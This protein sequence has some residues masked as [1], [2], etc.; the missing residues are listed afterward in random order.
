V[1]L[2][3]RAVFVLLLL[4]SMASATRAAPRAPNA[5]PTGLA[6]RHR[7]GQTFLTWQEQPGA[8]LRYRVYRHTTAIDAGNLAQATL[9]YDG[10]PQDSGRFYAN[11][12]NVD[13]GGVW[14]ERYV[15][16]FVVEDGGAEL[17]A[18][19][20]LLVWTLAPTD[21]G[22][23][24]S[25][26]GYYA[27]TTVDAG[28][29]NRTDFGAGNTVGPVAESVADPLPVEIAA[30]GIDPGG[31]I[32]VQYMPLRDWNVTFH[33][34]NPGNIFY[35]LDETSPAVANAIQY[36]YD[37][38]VY[39]PRAADCGGAL[40]A[41][42]PVVVSLHGWG[43]NSYGP[44][45]EDPDPYGWCVYRIYPI[46][47]SET[48]WFGFARNHDYRGDWTPGAGD[49]IAN[50]T[51]RRV[52][53]MV[54]DLLRDPPGPPADANRVFIFGSSM[55]GSGTLAFALRYPNV[56]AA[57]YA[58]QPMTNYATSGDGGGIDWRSD[59]TPKWGEV[60]DDLPV[61]ITG[62]GN[63]ADG[64]QAENGTGVWT[65]QNHQAQAVARRASDAVPLGI[66]HGVE[67]DV[68]EW[69]TQGRPIYPALNSAQQVWGGAAVPGGHSWTGFGGSLYN[70]DQDFAASWAPFQNFAPRRGETVPG[71][72]N[73]S[74]NALLPPTGVG[75]YN[76]GVRWSAS[77]DP[78]D[79]APVDTPTRWE[80]SFCYQDVDRYEN[81]CGTGQPLTVDVTPRRV[82][83]FPLVA[84][85]GYRWENRRVSDNG[86][87]ASGNVTADADGLVTV[88]AFALNHAGGNRLILQPL[89]DLPTPTATPTPSPTPTFCPQATPEPLWVEPVVSPTD[90]LTQTIVVNIGNCE[91]VTVTT[92]SGVFT[93]TGSFGAVGNPASV[94]IDLL[95][96]VT[97]DLT[98]AARVRSS[99]SGGC[100]FGGYTL[101][102]Q[103]D[104][105]GGALRIVQQAAGVQRGFLPVIQRSAATAT[106][107]PTPTATSTSTPTSTLMPTV[108]PT[109]TPTRTP[110][111]TATTTGGAPRP[112][113]D[114]S[115]GI[116]VFNDQ[117]PPYLSDAQWAFAATHYAGV[118]K[119]TRTDA[120]TLRSYNPNLLILHYRLGLG[121]GYRAIENG[122]QP[123]GAYIHLVEGGSWVQ[124]WPGDGAVEETWFAHWPENGTT[125]VLNC[126]WGWWLME[127]DD[128]GWRAYWQAEV[129]RQVQAND[130]DGVFMDSLSVPNYLGGDRYGPALPAVD[131]EYEQAWATRIDAWLAWLQTQ[132]VGAYAIV[133]NVG[134]WV[135]T[136]D[137]TTY[138]AADGV[139]IEGFAMWGEASPLAVDDWRLQ[140]NRT[141]GV[142]R[143][144]KAVIA[145][146]YPGDGRERFFALGSYLLIKGNHTYLN[147]ETSEEPEWWPEYG[148][149][150][151][152]PLHGPVAD[153]DDLA[154]GGVYRRDFT[155][156]FVLVNP[157]EDGP[158][159]DVDLG[160]LFMR[161]TASG[162]GPVP[163]NGIPTGALTH[164]AVSSVSLPPAS[165]AVLLPMLPD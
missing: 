123:T 17:A 108:T 8:S 158:A 76:L 141:L 105:N 36:A 43:G 74:T 66:A 92:A 118:Q 136:R 164:Q 160:A 121:L 113:P 26:A 126:D 39:A 63:W 125:R 38:A 6:A 15:E 129:L 20:G 22:G 14:D 11:R 133:P 29:E 161:V 114:T 130:N 33:A 104:R 148:I 19:V 88:P 137:P 119:M 25:G 50:F 68:I 103:Q 62:P 12:Y 21:F 131:A 13:A 3:Y 106:P 163:E 127:L 100:P 1:P 34:P 99:S 70:L 27:I 80:M 59:L 81:A 89:D 109:R 139:M 46:D 49:S 149:D 153:I 4:L 40:P 73:G 60:A 54:Y 42:L 147:L 79:G 61:I 162:G 155:G 55:G 107:T 67:D 150:I 16:R 144:G 138:A 84:G 122:C 58:G 32:F 152:S 64:L 78:W 165:A 53:R 98:V 159:L 116:H 140:M 151:G 23:G 115:D 44:R 96:G 5:Q 72:S 94:A 77:W 47:Q 132:P 9:L 28:G 91:T 2:I 52:L 146:A 135:T 117:L 83:H 45:T 142:I 57:A 37:Y 75:D 7:S 41:Q 69:S 86:L 51:E 156:G 145:Q 85:A 124:E 111:P 18:G 134:S 56:F 97:H 24:Q 35:G 154:T 93:A 157:A 87:V 10:V 31:H 90:R 82:Q 110:T 120:D 71:L 95:P 101:T 102:T 30:P 65:W 112:W 143:Q 128:P 48:W